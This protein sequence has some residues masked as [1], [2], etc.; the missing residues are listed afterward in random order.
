MTEEDFRQYV[1][2]FNAADFAGFGRFYA[3]DV[4]FELGSR[5]RIVGRENI[6]AFYREV[7]AH[8]D[9]EVIP[10]GIMV[11][12]RHAAMYCRTT[13]RTVVDWPD[14]EFGPTVAGDLREVETIAWY[15]LDDSGEHFTHIRGGRFKP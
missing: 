7:R 3:D 1:A 6:L 9:E 15:E 2:A 10:L 8:I 4:V 13:F 11:G 14:Y 12:P 5:K